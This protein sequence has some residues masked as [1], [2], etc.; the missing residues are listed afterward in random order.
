MLTFS[1]P[2]APIHVFSISLHRF[3]SLVEDD[4]VETL[5]LRDLG[6]LWVESPK[7]SKSCC[8]SSRFYLLSISY[9]QLMLSRHSQKSQAF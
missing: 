2:A 5:A 4:F 6:D 8:S 7:S 3:P 1:L 9:L